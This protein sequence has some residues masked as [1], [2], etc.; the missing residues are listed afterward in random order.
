[1]DNDIETEPKTRQSRP[2]SEPG[3]V[4]ETRD[5]ATEL[6]ETSSYTTP[7][8]RNKNSENINCK[9]R[10]L[11]VTPILSCSTIWF[12]CVLHLSCVH[13]VTLSYHHSIF[14]VF[15]NQGQSH[16]FCISYVIVHSPS[17]SFY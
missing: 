10:M 15:T 9:R 13:V 14:V 5:N 4:D 6:R 2:A 3:E 16:S 1:M 11:C 7:P 17:H 12:V 8:G